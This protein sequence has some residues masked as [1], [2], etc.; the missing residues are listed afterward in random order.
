MRTLPIFRRP[1]LALPALLL[2]AASATRVRLRPGAVRHRAMGCRD[3]P[4]AGAGRAARADAAAA[5]ARQHRGRAHRADGRRRRH[6]GGR[7]AVRRR[8]ARRRHP[9]LLRAVL[10]VSRRHHGAGGL[11][12]A[13]P[14]R[15]GR[16]AAGRCRRAARQVVA[17]DAGRGEGERRDRPRRRRPRRLW[18]A[19]AARRQADR[20]R[21]RR[22]ARP[23]GPSPRG[24]RRRAAARCC[25]S[26]IAPA[27]SG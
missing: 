23:S 18:R 24:W 2:L 4:P 21:T 7:L 26:T 9:A 1:L 3:D 10:H 20:G 12:G 14:G 5:D 16:T 17:A 8:P 6:R 25:R 13:G 27:C 22:R 15:S 19:A 11:A